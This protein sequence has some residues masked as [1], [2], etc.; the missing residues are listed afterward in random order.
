MTNTIPKKVIVIDSNFEVV[1]EFETPVSSVVVAKLDKVADLADRAT[2][3]HYAAVINNDWSFSKAPSQHEKEAAGWLSVNAITGGAIADALLGK[4]VKDYDC[5]FVT[6]EPG[7][8]ID[9]RNGFWN[10]FNFEGIQYPL[11]HVLG[12]LTMPHCYARVNGVF[13]VFKAEKHNIDFLFTTLSEDVRIG[14]PYD[15]LRVVVNEYDQDIKMGFY[16]NSTFYIHEDMFAAMENNRV[17]F[18]KTFLSNLASKGETVSVKEVLRLVK[19]RNKYTPN[20][21]YENVVDEYKLET[22]K[23]YGYETIFNS[24]VTV[25]STH[26]SLVDECNSHSWLEDLQKGICNVSG[27]FTVV[28]EDQYFCEKCIA[29]MHAE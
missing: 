29:K 6:A 20:T 13:Q 18:N 22:I 15:I 28:A 17:G 24:S 1:T 9:M 21:S 19:A 3:H 16:Y 5:L 8:Q 25:E 10:Y 23:E 14:N 2:V 4:E 27:C 26:P 7:D 11:S 12:F